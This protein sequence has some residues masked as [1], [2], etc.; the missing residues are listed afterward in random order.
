[1]PDSDDVPSTISEKNAR[2]DK[3]PVVAFRLKNLTDEQRQAIYRS[4]MANM[5][6]NQLPTSIGTP[7]DVGTALPRN[8][9]LNTLPAEVTNRIPEVKDLQFGFSGDKLVLAD[10]LY[11]EVLAVIP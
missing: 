4:V 2:D 5:Q 9:P 10:P 7:V 8:L 11:H 6:K 3:L 1:M